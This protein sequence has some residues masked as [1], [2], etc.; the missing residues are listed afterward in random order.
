[1]DELYAR[2]PE[3]LRRCRHCHSQEVIRSP[4]QRI[5]YCAMCK[6]HVHITAGTFFH[7]VRKVRPWLAAIWLL[8]H[9]V[10]VN[11]HKLSEILALAYDTAR[12]IFCKLALV[13]ERH[14]ASDA[15]EVPGSLLAAVICKRS[16]LTPANQHPIAE[17][18]LYESFDLDAAPIENKALN[19]QSEQFG[20]TA[21]EQ[22]V[23]NL[24]SQNPIGID[25]LCE[26]V[27]APLG[28]IF[29]ALT[30]LEIDGLIQRRPFDRYVL[31]RPARSSVSA[32]NETTMNLVKSTIEFV[33][34]HFHG[35][36][37]KCLQLY[38]VAFWCVSDRARWKHGALLE[39][40]LASAPER[41]S[42]PEYVSPRLVR[43]L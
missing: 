13:M 32:L 24:L 35:V 26:L 14:I 8:E 15:A 29:S 3:H 17:E 9:G 25:S 2:F 36:S 34:R 40:C 22:D 42:I 12:N 19:A 18:E 28:E 21:T 23:L 39:A 4:G 10:M 1:M 38:A 7:R 37:R 11:A 6:K 33:Q 16:R 41:R 27:V 20:R 5:G 30:M 31:T 43:L